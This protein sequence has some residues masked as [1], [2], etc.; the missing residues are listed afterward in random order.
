MSIN[1]FIIS[2]SVLSI[3]LFFVCFLVDQLKGSFLLKALS[4]SGISSLAVV[5]IHYF[6][7]HMAGNYLSGDNTTLSYY[8]LCPI[9]ICINIFLAARVDVLIKDS[10][11]LFERKYLLVVVVAIT[12]FAVF[13]YFSDAYLWGLLVILVAQLLLCILVAAPHTLLFGSSNKKGFS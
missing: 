1:F 12:C 10:N 5:P 2:F 9:F 4:I 13:L 11:I 8:V 3:S 6:I 7:L